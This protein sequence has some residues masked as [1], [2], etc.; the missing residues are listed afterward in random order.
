MSLYIKYNNQSLNE[1]DSNTDQAYL[2]LQSEYFKKIIESIYQIYHD[3][4]M[5]EGKNIK[6]VP[7]MKKFYKIESDKIPTEKKIEFSYIIFKIK[8]LGIHTS[9]QKSMLTIGATGQW[10]TDKNVK[11]DI[12]TRD[13]EPDSVDNDNVMEVQFR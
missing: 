3:Y 12:P 7:M 2:L 6:L 11:L 13:S 5:K 9:H 4:E 10:I 1:D 8:D